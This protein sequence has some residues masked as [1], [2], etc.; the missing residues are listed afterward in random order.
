MEQLAMIQILSGVAAVCF[1]TGGYCIGQ[2]RG[3]KSIETGGLSPAESTGMATI[4]S[5]QLH[6]SIEQLEGKLR[7]AR[8][9]AE[10]AWERV[11]AFE[12]LARERETKPAD[13]KPAGS[14]IAI[15]PTAHLQAALEKLELANAEYRREALEARE[16]I[17]ALRELAQQRENNDASEAA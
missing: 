3:S 2:F 15:D 9:D 6:V 16:T 10:D 5:A 7:E 13:S 17:S 11:R 1:A 8:C 12:Q 4:D 14:S